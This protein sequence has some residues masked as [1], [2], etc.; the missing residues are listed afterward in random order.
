[1]RI[2][3]TILVAGVAAVL[4]LRAPAAHACGQGGNNYAAAYTIALT[5]LALDTGF[6][7]WSVG[8]AA[9]SHKPSVGYGV[10]ELVIAGPQF[11]LGVSTLGQGT[12]AWYPAW[13]GALTVHAIWTIASAAGDSGPPP[14]EDPQ[15]HAFKVGPTFV[16]DGQKSVPGLGLTGRF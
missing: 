4:T 9:A 10:A 2:Q 15:S 13:M 16:P 1:M 8:S 7:L 12:P 6:T 5:A 3:S 14:I 11:A